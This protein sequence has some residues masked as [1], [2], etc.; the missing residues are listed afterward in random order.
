MDIFLTVLKFAAEFGAWILLALILAFLVESFVEY[1]FGLFF[2]YI[3]D[4]FQK[5]KKLVL[6]LVAATVG[7]LL[8]FFYKL[9]LIYILTTI[10]SMF[11]GKEPIITITAPGILLTGLG[12]GRGA[13]YIHQF[14]SQYIPAPKPLPIG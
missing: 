7:V 9:D 13:N 14:I 5:F 8:C 3:P 10:S 12:V 4:K 2:E 11:A 6:S 1:F